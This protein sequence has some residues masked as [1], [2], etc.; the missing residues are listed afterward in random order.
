MILG[1]SILQS[2]QHLGRATR[3]S[4]EL[5]QSNKHET[6]PEPNKCLNFMGTN[7]IL[8]RRYRKYDVYVE[9]GAQKCFLIK[10]T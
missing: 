10:E 4:V 1:Q 9:G 3:E 2:S 5:T 8:R 6:Y 7:D